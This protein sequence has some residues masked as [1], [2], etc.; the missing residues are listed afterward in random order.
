MRRVGE[1]YAHSLFAYLDFVCYLRSLHYT[2]HNGLEA[3][4]FQLLERGDT[5]WIPY[6]RSKD[7][8]DL[9]KKEGLSDGKEKER[10]GVDDVEDGSIAPSDWG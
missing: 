1:S 4:V 10:E 5:S 8:D 7:I 3:Y 6:R 2:S 9:R